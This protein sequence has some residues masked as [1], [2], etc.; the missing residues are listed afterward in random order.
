[1]L[2]WPDASLAEETP[3]LS[4]IVQQFGHLH[5]TSLSC[6]SLCI[7]LIHIG[8]GWIRPRLQ[9][10]PYNLHVPLSCRMH[11]GGEML[12][13]IDDIGIRTFVKQDFHCFRERAGGGIKQ[14]GPA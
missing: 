14:G 10:D 6:E 13:R 12:T 9:Q 11:Q 7:V 3:L 8:K 2:R 4:V 5:M 1:M